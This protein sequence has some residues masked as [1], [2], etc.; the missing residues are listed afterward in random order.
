MFRLARTS[1]ILTLPKII[2]LS[3]I[4]KLPTI[5]RAIAAPRVGATAGIDIGKSGIVGIR[6]TAAGVAATTESYQ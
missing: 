6:E 1:K 2:N 5:L 4:I 3:T